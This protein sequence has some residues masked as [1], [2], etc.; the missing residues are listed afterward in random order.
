M[1]VDRMCRI[2]SQSFRILFLRR[3]RQPLPLTVRSCRCG[4]LLDSFGHHRSA[5]LVAGVLGTRGF[6]LENATARIC[7]EGGGRVRTNV[8]VRDMDIGAFNP[9]DTRR[10][11]VVVDGLPLFRARK[12]PW[13]PHWFAFS[14]EKESQTS[15]CQRQRSGNHC[16]TETE[17]RRYPELTGVNVRAR[18]VVLAAEVGGRFSTETSHF[19]NGLASAKVRATSPAGPPKPRASRLDSSVECNAWLHSCP[20][21][22]CVSPRSGAHWS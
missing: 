12:P 18:L 11:D 14:R 20:G 16:S 2:E 3:P 17:R 5:C 13:T 19:L 4:R 9:H 6:P 22:R 15:V 1:P 10:L 21:L 7:R 8:L